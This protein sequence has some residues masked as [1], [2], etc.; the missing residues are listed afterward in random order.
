MLVVVRSGETWTEEKP[1]KQRGRG[2]GTDVQGS[3]SNHDRL[4]KTGH[5]GIRRCS[6][7]KGNTLK[8]LMDA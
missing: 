6:I 1:A 2:R 4:N 8:D 5:L 7:G 3:I